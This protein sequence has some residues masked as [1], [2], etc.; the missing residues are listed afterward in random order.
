MKCYEWME[1][2]REREGRERGRE[3]LHGGRKGGEGR[4]MCCGGV[5]VVDFRG[6]K[7]IMSGKKRK[8]EGV[9]V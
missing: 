3:Q 4:V 1:E 5:L 2:F 6:R 9:A 7:N 8:G